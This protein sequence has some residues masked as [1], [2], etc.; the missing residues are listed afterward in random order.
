M[1]TVTLSG[2]GVGNPVASDPRGEPLYTDVEG[3]MVDK[4]GNLYSGLLKM[5]NGRQVVFQDGKYYR[6][7]T[8]SEL[9]GDQKTGTEEGVTRKESVSTMKSDC[10]CEV[11]K[12][13]YNLYLSKMQTAGSVPIRAT[14]NK[15]VCQ[16]PPS[17]SPDVPCDEL[18]RALSQ[19]KQSSSLEG[20]TSSVID[21]VK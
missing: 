3:K 20:I 12:I 8:A 6:E 4:Y 2:M 15:V 14:Q 18:Q 9:I 7:A 10:P 16:T 1:R 11:K 19:M 13:P 17:Q 5:N 21:T